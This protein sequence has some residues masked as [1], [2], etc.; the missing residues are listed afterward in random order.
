MIVMEMM[1][2]LNKLLLR[3]T[4]PLLDNI[5]LDVSDIHIHR[6]K[7]KCSDKSAEV[8]LWKFY[9]TDRPTE[10]LIGKFHFQIRCEEKR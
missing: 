6:R 4:K 9:R 8:K 10:G 3:N 5:I 1:K 7:K 2:S